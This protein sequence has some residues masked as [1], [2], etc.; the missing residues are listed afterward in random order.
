MPELAPAIFRSNRIDA[1]LLAAYT[2]QNGQ[3]LA[4]LA[5]RPLFLVFL[6]HFGCTFCREAVDEIS[7][8][9]QALEFTRKSNQL[10]SALDVKDYT[11]AEKL[12][13]ELGKI[14]KDFDSSK[15]TGLVETSKTVA[16]MHLAKA[17]NAALSG[18]LV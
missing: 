4:E 14:A 12:V 18:D 2:S 13:D 3:S 15:P 9:R 11:L 8:K 5:S 10:I 7:K 16:Q 17:R 1:D 6:R